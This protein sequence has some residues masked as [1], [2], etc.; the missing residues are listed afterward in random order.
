[1]S[2]QDQNQQIGV[3]TGKVVSNKMD[4]SITV[5]IERYVK[6]PL[7]GKRLR[8][9]SKYHAHDEQN[10]CQIG[11]IVKIRETK[12][13]SKTKSWMLVEVVEKAVSA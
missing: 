8:R 7:Y 13:I 6:H 9:S 2:N 4:K 5:L 12:P 10:T 11:D 1:M 3:L